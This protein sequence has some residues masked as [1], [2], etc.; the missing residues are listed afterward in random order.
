MVVLQDAVGVRKR[1][2]EVVE[3]RLPEGMSSS[4]DVDRAKAELAAT[5]ALVPKLEMA[6]SQLRGALAVLTGVPVTSLKL[7]PGWGGVTSAF[8]NRRLSCLRKCCS[9]V[10]MFRQHCAR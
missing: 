2:L 10:R 8:P 4:F 7:Q 3:G 6:E 9:A 5:E 1:T